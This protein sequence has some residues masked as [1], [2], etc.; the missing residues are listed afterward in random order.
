MKKHFKKLLAVAVATGLMATMTCMSVSA[1]EADGVVTVSVEK[2]SI[3]QGYVSQPKTVPFYEGDNGIDIVKRAVGEENVVVTDGGWGSYISGFVDN[4][5]E[6]V[7][8]DCVAEVLDAS[9]FTGR[10]DADVL[11]E[12]DY[13]SESGFMFFINC[14]SASVGISD[15]MPCDGDVISLRFSVY[16]YGADVGCDNSSW[17]GSE[18]LIGDV[19]RCE[20]T[21][22]IAEVNAVG[23]V[24][25]SDEIAVICDLDSTQEEIDLACKN[26]EEKLNPAEETPDEEIP[27]E[28]NEDKK[29]SDTGFSV[30]MLLPAVIGA[31]AIVSKK[32]DKI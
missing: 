13:T 15:Y 18:S 29:P 21:K 28:D 22:L 32:K 6:I 25:I 26:I 10:A 24:D 19:D 2:F 23:N 31:C 17:G 12:F 5:G 3:G 7:L 20:A 30:G 8:P 1:E 14:D 4:E 16:G 9:T 11:S 27:K